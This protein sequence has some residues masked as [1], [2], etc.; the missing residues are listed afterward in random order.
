[1]RIAIVDDDPVNLQLVT[2]L[3]RKTG[4]GEPVPFQNPLAG[5][6]WCTE[7]DVDLLIVDFQMPE[8]DGI[9]FIRSFRELPDK[10]DTPILMVT[11]DQDR[12]TRYEALQCGATDFLTKPVDAI[13]F[14]ARLRN[15]L[16]LR[17]SQRLLADR[18][19][20]LAA[21]V[22]TA[23]AEIA[24]REDEMI[25]R[26]SRAA[27]FRDPET[28]AHILR[29]A[30]YSHIIAVQMGLRP[31]QC[32][33]IMKAAP[34]HDIGK[35]AIPDHILLK[36]GKLTPDEFE[37]MKGHAE[38]G[39]QILRG[40]ASQMLRIAAG[41]ARSHHEKYDGTGYPL[42]LST[43]MIPLP[44]RIVAVADVFDALTSSRPYKKAWSVEEALQLLTSGSGSH[45]DPV[46]ISAF[47]ARLDEVRAIK[48]AYPAEELLPEPET[49]PLAITT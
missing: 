12:Q 2:S 26:L 9:S 43:G 4:D 27:E 19:A 39:Y 35:V 23:T 10:S 20:H 22:A 8:I 28:G 38:T 34:M 21:E 13:E 7:N 46:C 48:D 11:G 42:G 3:V 33:L 36:P 14:R 17:H 31:G 5:L 18:A 25:T 45:F 16:A 6:L 15:M 32:D 29:M 30:R 44:A 49:D 24:R 41:I 40:S 47:M 1:M 37:I